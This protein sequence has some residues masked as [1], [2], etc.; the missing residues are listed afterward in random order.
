MKAVRVWVTVL[1][2][3]FASAVSLLTWFYLDTIETPICGNPHVT[4]GATIDAAILIALAGGIGESVLI[5]GIKARSQL[6]LGAL[7]LGIATIGL[8]IDLVAVDSATYT[9]RSPETADCA[10]W[11]QTS[12]VDF[13][14]LLWGVPLAVLILQALRAGGWPIVRESKG[15]LPTPPSRRL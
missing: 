6:L 1:S 8:A 4:H 9:Q 5:L 15:S 13:L 2:L 10:P 14:Y 3:L 12:H 7:F 11:T